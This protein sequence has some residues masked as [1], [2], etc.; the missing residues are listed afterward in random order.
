ML[1][2]RYLISGFFQ[3]VLRVLSKLPPDIINQ[4]LKISEVF[5]EEDFELGSRDESGSLMAALILSK[6]E[7]DKATED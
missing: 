4:S 3:Q 5:S 2:V 1:K 6:S 7:A